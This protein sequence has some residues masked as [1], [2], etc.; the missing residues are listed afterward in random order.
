MM[1]EE[2]TRLWKN[3]DRAEADRIRRRKRTRDWKR[4]HPRQPAV[5]RRVVRA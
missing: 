2:L 1:S 4:A 3:I 5:G